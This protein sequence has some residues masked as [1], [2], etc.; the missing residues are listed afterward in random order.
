MKEIDTNKYWYKSVWG[1]ERWTIFESSI[2]QAECQQLEDD[3]WEAIGY[4]DFETTERDPDY[5]NDSVVVRY[6]RKPKNPI[7][8]DSTEST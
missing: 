6:F 2:F 1:I 7:S 5:G 8:G 4:G 3:G